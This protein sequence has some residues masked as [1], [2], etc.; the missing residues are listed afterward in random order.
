MSNA[1]IGTVKFF[2]TKKGFGF[3]TPDDGGRDAFVHITAVNDSRVGDL[4]EGDRLSFTL[5]QNRG[6]ECACNLERVAK[7]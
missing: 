5:Q 3:I 2:D 6:K 4:K 1:Q 7:A